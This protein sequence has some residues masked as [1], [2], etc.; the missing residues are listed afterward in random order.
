MRLQPSALAADAVDLLIYGDIGESWWGESVTAQA[1]ATQLNAL[2]ASVRTINVRINSYGGSVADGLAIYNSLRRHPAF[3]AVTIDG[4]AMSSASLIAMA[5]DE[6]TMPAA[7]ILMIHA[8]WTSLS[9]NARELREHAD[10][11][12]TFSEAMAQAYI[13]KSGKSHAE[14]MDLLADGE[15]HYFTGDEAV[16]EGFADQVEESVEEEI[17]TAYLSRGLLASRRLAERFSARAPAYYAQLAVAAARRAP[18]KLHHFNGDTDMPGN[19]RTVPS[20]EDNTSTIEASALRARNQAMRSIAG[21]FQ[22]R[23]DVGADVQAAL[24]EA[25]ADPEATPESLSSTILAM[26]GRD[27]SP[28]GVG[29]EP[30]AR[31]AGSPR[32]D[33]VEA[34]SDVLA[35]RAGISVDKPHAG[36]RDV[37]RMSL[38]DIME[39]CASRSGTSGYGFGGG[40]ELV[41]AILTTS[42]FPAILENTLGKA[43]RAGFEA[44]PGTFRAWTRKVTVPD[45]KPQSRVILGSAPDLRH[46]LEGGEYERGS[47]D[48]DKSLPYAVG[49]FGR[50]INLTWETLVNDDLGAFLRIT[51][52]MGQAAARTEAD[53]I[54]QQFAANDGDGPWM[55]D[56]Q[57]LFH[58]SH[59]NTVE[60]QTGVN[61]AALGLARVKL[62]RQLALGGGVLNLPP[63]FLLVSPEHEQE[64]ETLLAAA[65]RS[66]NQGS[67]NALQPAWISR[68]ELVVEPRL[69][70]DAFYLLTSADNIDTLE[71]AY[72]DDH[73]GAAIER[74]DTFFV[75]GVNYKV[76]HVFGNRWL[77]WR[78]VVKVPVGG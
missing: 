1:V 7:S 38:R 47:M 76:R 52:A 12:D 61:A 74:E 69:S 40:R 57:P 48:E 25:L 68:L 42:D 3:K 58:A 75:D 6:V 62:R 43:L 18:P 50:I 44:E 37:Q 13:A 36:A 72:L 71:R 63:R 24:V 11:L 70:A 8:P 56:E 26:V 15:D 65:S 49:K 2:D 64:A 33:F 34:A 54:Y 32:R 78:G 30:N 10:V 28:V 51:Q 22:G 46:V 41:K 31:S 73:D 16:A 59:N 67:E 55:Q 5:G 23:E 19:T 39:A 14:V 27:T 4:V 60:P 21:Q 53:T 66:M 9:G 17:E 45:F 29:Y 20:A 77:D 35:M